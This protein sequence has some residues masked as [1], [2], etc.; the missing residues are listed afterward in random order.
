[1]NLKYE[2]SPENEAIVKDIINKLGLDYINPEQVKCVMSFKSASKRTLARLHPS[3]IIFSYAFDSKPLYIIELI[4]ENFNQLNEK[5]KLKVL[6]HE[7][8]HIPMKFS[9]EA[10]HH[11]NLGNIAH[12]GKMSK[13][14]NANCKTIDKL[15]N[16]Y[17][18]KAGKELKEEG[19]IEK[20]VNFL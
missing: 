3:F 9:G 17:C 14:I 7:L 19:L 10:R 16:E 8:M 18:Q 2:Q 12:N 4:S 6:I 5:E 11:G 13:Y 20:F 15:F 1:V